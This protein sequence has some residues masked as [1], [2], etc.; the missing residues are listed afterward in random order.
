MS[1]LGALGWRQPYPNRAMGH[2]FE[3]GWR[4][5][6]WSAALGSLGGFFRR[7]GPASSKTLAAPPLRRRPAMVSQHG[8]LLAVSIISD[9]FGPLVSVSRPLLPLPPFLSVARRPLLPLPP[10]RECHAL[11]PGSSLAEGDPLPPA[12]RRAFAAGGYPPRPALAGAS[13]ERPPRPHPAQL[14]PGLLDPQRQ[15]RPPNP[16]FIASDS[17]HSRILTPLLRGCRGQR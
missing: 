2:E 1:G 3:F 10:P 17:T 8:I 12:P 15:A 16:Y 7:E 6:T 5:L 9:H 4:Y 14:C 11:T 13:E